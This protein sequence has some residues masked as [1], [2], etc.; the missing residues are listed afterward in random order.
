MPNKLISLVDKTLITQARFLIKSVLS[1]IKLLGKF[2]HSRHRSV[3][4]PFV[5]MFA[6]LINQQLLIIN[7]PLH[8]CCQLTNSCQMWS[9]CLHWLK[10][11]FSFSKGVRLSI[12]PCVRF[13]GVIEAKEKPQILSSVFRRGKES[14][15]MPPHLTPS[16]F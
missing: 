15:L 1:K 2:E 12:P 4:N 7:L 10:Y 3:T 9:G 8:L 5:K 6:A 14:F 11:R 13:D 16:L